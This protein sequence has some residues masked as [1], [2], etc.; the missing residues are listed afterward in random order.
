M[1]STNLRNPDPPSLP[2]P[3]VCPISPRWKGSCGA[4]RPNVLYATI[5]IRR[6]R[7]HGG[8]AY[9]HPGKRG[10]TRPSPYARVSCSRAARFCKD[11]SKNSRKANA[12]LRLQTMSMCYPSQRECG[13]TTYGLGTRVSPGTFTGL[14]H[15]G[16]PSA[17][18]N[19]NPHQIFTTLK[20]ILPTGANSWQKLL[21]PVD[22]PHLPQ[23]T[24]PNFALCVHRA[25]G[26]PSNTVRAADSRRKK[27]RA[28]KKPV[29]LD[30][31]WPRRKHYGAGSDIIQLCS[32]ILLI[33]GCWKIATNRLDAI[34]AGIQIPTP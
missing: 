34:P 3:P 11:G 23:H 29:R 2:A 22:F 14:W 27:V 4:C 5:S 24:C 12:S 10:R 26:V 20:Q 25:P 32:C 18:E 17:Y 21:L 13:K 33:P 7:Q 31:P 1:F 28:K 30:C 8:S 15:R 6:A 19:A 9:H 16:R